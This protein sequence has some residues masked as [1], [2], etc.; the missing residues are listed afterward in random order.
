MDEDD[1][2]IVE[3]SFEKLKNGRWKKVEDDPKD[4]ESEIVSYFKTETVYGEIERLKR[5]G[6]KV[7][8]DMDPD[9]DGFI[10]YFKHLS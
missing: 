3:I 6:W 1:V 4:D 9:F 5:R 8:Q 2:D 10:L 7:Y